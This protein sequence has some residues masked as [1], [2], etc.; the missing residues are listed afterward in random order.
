MCPKRGGMNMSRRGL[1]VESAA[2]WSGDAGS[3]PESDNFGFWCESAGS[4]PAGVWWR[5]FESGWHGFEPG[6]GQEAR[7][8]ARPGPARRIISRSGR[9]KLK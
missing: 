2:R 1:A 8:R 7:V 9:L 4:S 6:W 5:G 3:S